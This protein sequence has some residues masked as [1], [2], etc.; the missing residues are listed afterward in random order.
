MIEKFRRYE[1]ALRERAPGKV[2]EAQRLADDIADPAT[3]DAERCW[4]KIWN[5]PLFANTR[6]KAS[7]AKWRAMVPLMSG[8]WREI[9]MAGGPYNVSQFGKGV[10]VV[11]FSITGDL[12]LRIRAECRVAPHRMLAIQGAAAAL[13]ARAVHAPRAPY[14]DL[15]AMQPGERVRAVQGE[16]KTFWGHVTALHFLTD[17]GLGCK[18]DLHLVQSVRAL[19]LVQDLRVGRVPTFRQAIAINEA[20]HQLAIL[21]YGKPTPRNLR[22]IDKILME[23]SKQD[24]LDQADAKGEW[25]GRMARWPDCS[26]D[27]R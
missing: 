5:K 8:M 1:V 19:G 4:D 21:L 9:G 12:A 23:V 25:S 17:L 15:L 27:C 20:V 7:K 13:R 3:S 10:K 24:V 2:E 11:S 16:N 18:P 26:S 22:Y 6:E 14:A